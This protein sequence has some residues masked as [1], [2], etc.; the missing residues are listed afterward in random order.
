MHVEATVPWISVKQL[1]HL[2]KDVSK[3]KRHSARLTLDITAVLYSE[4]DWET[5]EWV[6][7]MINM[8]HICIE[9]E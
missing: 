2:L 8:K 9:I 5:S 1:V 3:K 4:G 7:Y 6:N